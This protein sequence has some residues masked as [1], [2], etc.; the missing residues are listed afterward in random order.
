[1]H[2]NLPITLLLIHSLVMVMADEPIELS[3]LAVSDLSVAFFMARS[4]YAVALSP[5]Q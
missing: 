5:S 3:L 1:L 2:Q 4:G